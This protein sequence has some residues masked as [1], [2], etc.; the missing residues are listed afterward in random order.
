MNHK[1]S[2]WIRK[3]QQ[4]SDRPWYLPFL[5]TL[6]GLD[7]FLL[8]VPSDGLLVSSVMLRPKRWVRIC[9]WVSVGSA[10]G[11]LALSALVQWDS[12]WL[13]NSFPTLFQ[14]SH[15][16]STNAF[17][18]KHGAWALALFSFSILPQ[19]PAVIISAL[20]GM[21]LEVILISVFVGRLVKYGI[22]SYVASH[23]PRIINRLWFIRKEVQQLQET[24]V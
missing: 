18:D 21:P 19:Q 3:L 14:S 15:W 23:A 1:L 17:I 13:M 2:F 12:V 22:L 10:L 20:A 8:I 4:Y 16:E 7:L 9:I 5:A 24:E 11:A 6:I